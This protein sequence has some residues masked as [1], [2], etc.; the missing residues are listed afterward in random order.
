MKFNILQL[1]VR[2]YLRNLNTHPSY[3]DLRK[4][5]AKIHLLYLKLFSKLHNTGSGIKYYN[6]GDKTVGFY[7]TDHESINHL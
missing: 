5:R 6:I 1:S 3:R 2:A 4:V 7:H